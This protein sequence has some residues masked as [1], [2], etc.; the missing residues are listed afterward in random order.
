VKDFLGIGVAFVRSVL[1][2][3]AAQ[4]VY[5]GIVAT[6]GLQLC[7]VVRAVEIRFVLIDYRLCFGCK[8]L[9]PNLIK[10]D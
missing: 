7:F 9:H 8:L 2:E 10:K 3:H 5:I 4:G 6:I 1:S